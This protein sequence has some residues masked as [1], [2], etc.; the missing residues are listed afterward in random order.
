MTTANN[1]N[2][3]LGDVADGAFIGIGGSGLQRKPMAL[4]RELAASGATGL[5]IL[6]YLGSVDV[7]YLIAAGVVAEVHSAGVSLDGFGLAPAFRNSRQ[8]GSV[9]Y[10]EWSEG[11]LAASLEAA[12]VGLPSMP[13]PTSPGSALV[14]VNPHL[15]TAADPFDGS[16]TVFAQGLSLDLCLLHLSA[17][18]DVGNGYV[19]GDCAADQLLARAASRTVATA[20]EEVAAD[21][22]RAAIPRLWL[23]ETFVVESGSWPTGSHPAALV[24]VAAM[25]RWAG[26]GGSD[27]TILEARR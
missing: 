17:V 20:D 19:V 18:D 6:S 10:V 27:T 15:K 24:D 26:K 11:S 16:T 12:A 4:V 1:A 5:R 22:L 13:A 7:D 14:A 21:P 2:G 25:T 8:D 23:T 9:R 3:F